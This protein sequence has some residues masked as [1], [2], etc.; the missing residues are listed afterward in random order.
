MQRFSDQEISEFL[1][2]ACHDLRQSTRTVRAYSELLLK[3]VAKPQIP[4]LEKRLGL[5]ADGAGKADLLVDALARYAIALQ[6]DSTS[7]QPV[8]LD[9]LFRSV[10][11][12]LARDLKACEA[13]VTYRDLP[14]V[15]GNPDRLMD[16]FEILLRNALMHR[17]DASPRIDVA[18]AREG[19]EWIVTVHDNGP[20]VDSDSTE[21]I[22]KP[23][24]RAGHQRKG[25]GLGLTISREIVERHGGRIWLDLSAEGGATFRFSLPVSETRA[26]SLET[27]S[28]AIALR[29]LLI[30]IAGVCCAAYEDTAPA[31]PPRVSCCSAC[32]STSIRGKPAPHRSACPQPAPVRR[33][34]AH[35][36]QPPAPAAA[37]PVRLA[38]DATG[39]RL[40]KR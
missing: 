32:A 8:R 34:R 15:S 1:L 40:P 27:V 12:K 30:R 3:D 4:D 13:D 16:V 38:G 2:R 23:F 7:F 19:E 5:L 6:T 22:F 14:P 17:G 39:S 29:A 21:Q 26:R 35:W 36:R 31:F 24:V 25:V 10:L 28:A 11:A 37:A 33:C 18:A 20:A 9:V